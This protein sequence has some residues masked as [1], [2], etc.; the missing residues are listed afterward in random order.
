MT[1]AGIEPA[2]LRF[3]AQHLN[4][5]ATAVRH[6]S[7]KTEESFLVMPKLLDA[8]SKLR[9]ATIGVVMSVCLSAWNNSAPTGRIF[10]KFDTWVFFESRSRKFKFHENQTRISGALHMKP[11]IHYWQYLAQFFVEWEMFQTKAVDEIKTHIL[12][13]VTVFRKSFLL[14]DNVGKVPWSRTT[15]DDNMAHAYC[16]LGNYDTLSE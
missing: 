16:M 8:F 14:W 13:S 7:I 4:H 15:A 2:T 12:C 5:C 3:V 10:M 9:K 11:Y 6:R 1:P